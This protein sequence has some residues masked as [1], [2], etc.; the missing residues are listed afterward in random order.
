MDMKTGF[1]LLLLSLTANSW[2]QLTDDF[3]DGNFTA[4]P[5]WSGTDADFIVNAGNELQINNTIA[6]TSYL[7][8]PH[9]L[10]T[11]D[12]QEWRIWAKQ[13]FSPSS[14]NFGRIYLTS[15]AAD[16]TTNPD[17]FY[18]QL[19][20]AGSL[21]AIRL[22]K[23][24]SSV[25]TEI[26]AGTSAQIANSFTVGIRV[27]RNNA[28]LWS[29]YVDAAGGINYA[30]QSSGTDATNLLGTHFGVLGTYTL[31]NANKFFFDNVY[32]GPEIFDTQAPAI[33]SSTVISATQIDILFNEVV[34]GAAAT[35]AG[36]YALNPIVAVQSAVIDG[37]NGALVHLTLSGNLQNGQTYQ[38][39]VASIDDLAGNT[40]TNLTTNC[41]FLI[42]E[43]A[44][45]GDVIITEFM[46]DPTPAIGLPELEFIEI[47]NVS[48]KIFDLTDWRIGD[49][50]ADGTITAGWILPGEYKILCAT[51]SLPSFPTGFGV[52][53]FPSL[54]N[55]SDDVVLKDTGSVIID[56]VAYTDDWYNNPIKQEGGYTLELINPND[57][58]SDQANWTASNSL[59]GGT[60]GAQ[61]SVYDITPDTQAPSLV[62]ANALAP[63]QVE[64]YF[65]EGMD[66]TSVANSVMLVNPLLTVNNYS[67]LDPFPTSVMVTFNENLMASQLYTFTIGTLSDCWL[68]TTTLS[69]QFALA[70]LPIAGDLIINEILFD[71]GTGGT[72]F[73]ELFNRSSKVLNLKDYGIAN[74]DNDTIGDIYPIID[75]Y[76]LFPG[77]YVVLTAD[78]SFQKD[79]FPAAVAGTFYQMSIPAL[80][81]D[82]STIYLIYDSVVLDKVS[83]LA[84]WHLS[85]IDETENKTLERI[86]PAGLSNSKG[87]WHTA[88]EPIGF[89]TPGGQNSQYQIGGVTGDFGTVLPI[90][91]PDN[92]GLED[93]I[94]FFYTM[95]QPGMIATI[96]IF[97]D[98]GRLIREV[99]K[100]ELLGLTGNLSWDG[101]ND[102]NTKAG[103]G[104]YLAVME[105]FSVD[106]VTKFAKRVAFTLAGRLD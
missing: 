28:G 3:S 35:T 63:N 21:D 90:F 92:D 71:P 13:S 26:C 93:V 45:P 58:C 95:P 39:T 37:G 91:S 87:N 5:V 59:A 6:A 41:T 49:A 33:T 99:T 25:S 56:K 47:H 36:N 79:Q 31:S 102:N 84:D 73:V 54:N 61:N 10:S 4:N 18:L 105:A 72:D 19:G 14:S 104:V 48:N 85:L 80:N 81:N 1:L 106:G 43:I 23:S 50:S 101:V 9:G 52:T 17:G 44:A 62:L 86:D 83:Y 30:F 97:D 70:D 103:I 69:G 94:Q 51:S 38:L 16:L 64:L 76:L 96:R 57:P 53:S 42:S 15:A 67:I 32:A 12:G 60:P 78:S 40:A 22:F 74:F 34:S 55:A 65:S 46:A 100:S 11:L 77:E 2:A 27:V 75:N 82:S 29:L 88:A 20:E 98:Q 68:N 8:T 89:G 66:S 24:V 7:S